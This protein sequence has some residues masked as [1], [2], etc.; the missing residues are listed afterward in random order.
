MSKSLFEHT[1]WDAILELTK[2]ELELIPDSEM[3]VFF[4]KSIRGGISYISSRYS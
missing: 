3:Y 2:I 1:S 4:E